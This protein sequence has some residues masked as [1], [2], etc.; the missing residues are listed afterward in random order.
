MLYKVT[1]LTMYKYFGHVLPNL[2]SVILQSPRSAPLA[3]LGLTFST[4]LILVT[5]LFLYWVK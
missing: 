5:T 3:M 1:R 2:L 4:L